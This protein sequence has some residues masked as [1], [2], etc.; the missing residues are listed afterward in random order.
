MH[1][2]ATWSATHRNEK[3]E[4]VAAELTS[5]FKKLVASLGEAPNTLLT[6]SEVDRVL[7]LVDKPA[8]QHAHLWRYAIATPPLNVGYMWDPERAVGVCGDWCNGSKVEGAFMSGYLLAKA[9]L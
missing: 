2:K 5:A 7:S 3:P 6:S 4:K 9:M 8:I 1:G